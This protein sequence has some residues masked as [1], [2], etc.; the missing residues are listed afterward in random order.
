MHGKCFVFVIKV[1]SIKLT[2]LQ[3]WIVSRFPVLQSVHIKIKALE[4]FSF[5]GTFCFL[6]FGT[7]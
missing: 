4:N 5:N 1:R 2:P 7:K 6:Q 3:T